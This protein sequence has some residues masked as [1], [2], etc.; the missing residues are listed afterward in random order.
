[1]GQKY[2]AYDI[3]G[4][5]S[6]FYDSVDS[7]I[8]TSVTQTIELTNAQWQ[9]CANEQGRWLVADGE[10]VAAAPST[11]AQLLASAQATQI[12][13]LS[14]ACATAIVAGFTSSALGAA[15]TYPSKTTDQQNLS[16]SVIASLM[17]G[18][19]SGWATPF[20]CEDVNGNWAWVNHTAAQIQQ[21][22]QDGKAAILACMSK[23]AE[24][25]AEV[26]AATTIAAV[27]AVVWE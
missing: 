7:P 17:P 4:N 2:A 22:G 24:Y 21:V 6:A 5:I 1:M 19:T 15:H 11:H 14:F 25:A 18:L 20:W 8:P 16:A 13:I 23:N 26:L 12:S 3:E 27:Q 9:T 10:L